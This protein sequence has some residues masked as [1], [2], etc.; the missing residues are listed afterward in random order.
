[1]QFNSSPLPSEKGVDD[2]NGKTD[3]PQLCTRLI[4]ISKKVDGTWGF[5]IVIDRS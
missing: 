2:L 5:G 1:M 4:D 3:E